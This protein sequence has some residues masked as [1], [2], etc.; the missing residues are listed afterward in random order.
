VAERYY[1][2]KLAAER[3]RRCYEVAPPATL[4]YL[5]T[6]IEHVGAR[7]PESGRLLELGCGY[8]RALTRLPR[9]RFSLCGIDSSASSIALAREL[10]GDPPF[11]W[12][13]MDAVRLG[14]ADRAFDCTLCIQNGI[15]AFKVDRLDLMRESVRVTRPGGRVLFSS[16]AERFW[17]DRLDWFEAQAA[18]GLIGEIDRKAT[19][20]GVIVCK[21]GFRADTVGPDEFRELAGRLGL[22]PRI[23]EVAGA[24]LFCELVVQ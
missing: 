19:G 14:F 1:I 3:L 21:D 13:V 20:D 6:E 18:A 2:D 10:H 7:L 8:G 5:R 17:P 11:V 16:Y 4:V 9:A 15:S 24:S 12:A 23:V 22:E